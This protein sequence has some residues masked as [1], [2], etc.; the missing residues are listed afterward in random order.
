MII[1]NGIHGNPCR[2][3]KICHTVLEEQVSD[4][5][6]KATTAPIKASAGQRVT[7]SSAKKELSKTIKHNHGNFTNIPHYVK[8]FTT[9]KNVYTVYQ[10]SSHDIM[11]CVKYVFRLPWKQ[12][13]LISFTPSFAQH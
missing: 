8:L 6:T 5:V 9:V 3:I 11:W 1:D 13:R 12:P 10:V 4:V 7:K 2:C